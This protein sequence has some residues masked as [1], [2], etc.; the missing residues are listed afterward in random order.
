MIVMYSTV[1]YCDVVIRKSKRYAG[2]MF[3]REA[4]VLA[5]NFIGSIPRTLTTSSTGLLV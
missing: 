5:T 3:L 1:E 4:I 2:A